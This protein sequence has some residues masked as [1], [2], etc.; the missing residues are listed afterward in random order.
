MRL[1]SPP[2]VYTVLWVTV[3]ALADLQLTRQLLPMN[4]ATLGL[5]AA[6]VVSFW[7]IYLVMALAMRGKSD[8]V[9]A[10]AA[11]LDFPC[12]RRFAGR[13]TRFWMAGSILEI[14]V[15][16]GLPIQWLLAGD[17]SRDYRDFGV[18]SL[19]GL[20]TAVYLF[21]LTARF[22]DYC[23]NR[24]G[25]DGWATLA[26]LVWPLLQINR[27]AL[28]W[29]LL[30]MLGIF[31]LVRRVTPARILQVGVAMLLGILLFGVVGDWRA[32]AGK[33]ALREI[34][35]ERGRFLADDL[36]PGFL[37][38]YLYVSS[39]VNNVVGGIEHLTPL[40]R[41][42]Y[43]TASLLPTVV[44]ERIYTDTANRY[45]LGLVNEAF[46]AS[47]WYVN[48]LADFGVRGAIAIICV[49]QA[50]MSYFYLQAR[51]GRAWGVL[52]YGTLF[53]ALALSIFTDTLTS[54][55]T[56]A[57]LAI[58]IGYRQSLAAWVGAWSARRDALAASPLPQE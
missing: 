47:T 33:E 40:Y 16:G 53:Q 32:G 9:E 22:L 23:F 36:P 14:I 26:L 1:T 8:V 20:L 6:N 52:A 51:R 44:R 12:L 55:V 10:R 37:W 18:P 43:S 57:Q 4:P 39:P 13:L 15:A 35:S 11:G 29:S 41:P 19:H 31:L 30:E 7:V 21:I 5:I 54:L 45:A 48:F 38:V 56:I 58:V 17:T 25:R 28:I 49:I 3:V 24:R 34:T 42:Y 27:G 50:L 46:N 2:A